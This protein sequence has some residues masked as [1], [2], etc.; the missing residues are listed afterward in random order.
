MIDSLFVFYKALLFSYITY[1]GGDLVFKFLKL[2]LA[3]NIQNI[4]YRF[5]SG[6]S[7]LAVSAFIMASYEE[8]NTSSLWI[9]SV[10]IFFLS[11]ETVLKHFNFLKSETVHSLWKEIK[12]VYREQSFLKIIMTIWFV[13]NFIIVF[14]PV[15]GHDTLDYHLP[16]MQDLIQNQTLTYSDKID[17]YSYLPILGEILY[18]TPIAMFGE[19]SSPYIF[20]VIQ[21]SFLLLFVALVYDFTKKRT[22]IKFLPFVASFGMMAVMDF[23]R[24]IMHGGYIDVPSFLLSIASLFI[25]VEYVL[26]SKELKWPPI[27]LSSILIGVASSIKY[28][29]LFI[30]GIDG[31]I[32]IYA[33]FKNRFSL[34]KGLSLLVVFTAIFVCISGVWYLKN[35]ALY[36]NPVYPMISNKETT[37]QVGLFVRDRT[38]TNMMVF[39]F[40][41]FS[42]WFYFGKE[43]SSQLILLGYFILMYLLIL[44]SLFTRKKWSTT[45]IA[46]FGFIQSYFWFIFFVSHQNRFMLPSL[47]LIP[48]FLALMTEKVYSSLKQK[49]SSS[50]YD[51]FIRKSYFALS[52]AVVILL[53]GNLHYFYVRWKYIFGITDKK[54]YIIEIGGM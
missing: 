15:T 42:R 37:S 49:I 28:S 2:N 41:K 25:L 33:I 47:I 3:S 31:L 11:S 7:L 12:T 13:C 24:E 40:Y 21:Y 1:L 16:I 35:Y 32:L 6:M 8:F 34:K 23:E 5:L 14:V 36:D 52:F 17:S 48:L 54:A 22:K 44:W 18:A 53:I 29:A 4:V 27:I 46:L 50:S 19:R 30:F 51:K 38:I 9:L 10:V 43:S 39:P 20:Q 26:E 45:E